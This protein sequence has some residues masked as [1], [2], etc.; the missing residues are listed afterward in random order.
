MAQEGIQI[1]N[2]SGVEDLIKNIF[3]KGNCKNVSNIS[4][5]GNETL[6]IGQFNKGSNNIKISDKSHIG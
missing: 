2:H 6:S 1:E 5:I 3:I 4:V